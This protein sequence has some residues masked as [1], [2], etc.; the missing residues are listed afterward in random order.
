MLEPASAGQVLPEGTCWFAWFCLCCPRRCSSWPSFCSGGASS[1]LWGSVLACLLFL[2]AAAG[3]LY[4][5]CD[6]WSLWNAAQAAHLLTT[7][8]LRTLQAAAPHGGH[9]CPF[10]A[11]VSSPLRPAPQ[12]DR[13]SQQRGPMEPRNSGRSHKQSRLLPLSHWQ[14]FPHPRFPLQTAHSYSILQNF[15]RLTKLPFETGC[16]YDTIMLHLEIG[17]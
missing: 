8:Q 17:R 15:F 1:L 11:P 4:T 13:P 9:L 2:L 14:K 3:W 16:N 12:V 7:G 10:A 6:S 5:L